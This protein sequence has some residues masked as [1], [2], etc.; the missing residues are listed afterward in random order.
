MIKIGK[1][2]VEGATNIDRIF[3]Y[4]EIPN[5]INIFGD[6]RK[7]DGAKKVALFLESR[8]QAVNRRNC[9]NRRNRRNRVFQ[10]IGDRLLR[11]THYP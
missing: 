10:V 6:A 8:R 11:I 1:S 3:R 2:K 5:E 9:K 4:S 7:V